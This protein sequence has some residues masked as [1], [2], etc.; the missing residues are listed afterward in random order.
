MR[1]KCK[2]GGKC[3][4][5]GSI[6]LYLSKSKLASKILEMIGFGVKKSIYSD[7]NF[8]K[9]EMFAVYRF[10]KEATRK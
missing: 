3:P 6:G 9:E 5:C 8:S 7:G 2:D 10:A 4:Y 1:V